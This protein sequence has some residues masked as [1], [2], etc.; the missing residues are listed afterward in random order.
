MNCSFLRTTLISSTAASLSKLGHAIAMQ[1]IRFP[2][3]APLRIRNVTEGHFLKSSSE[4]SPKSS[5]Q[6]SYLTHMCR[7]KLPAIYEQRR[8]FSHITATLLATNGFALSSVPT[9]TG[10]KYPPP[11]SPGEHQERRPTFFRGADLSSLHAPK[12]ANPPAHS[13]TRRPAANSQRR[14]VGQPETCSPSPR[15]DESLRPV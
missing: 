4:V 10:R 15:V 11:S 2:E 13:P 3:Q 8:H 9:N 6:H 1:P 5:Q 7:W 14:I 12:R